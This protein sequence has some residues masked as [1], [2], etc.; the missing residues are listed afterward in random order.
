MGGATLFLQQTHL[1]LFRCSDAYVRFPLLLQNVEDLLHE[2]G[3]D[4]S[5]ERVSSGRASRGLSTSPPRQRADRCADLGL[6]IGLF[7][8]SGILAALYKRDD[9]PE[10]QH[11]EVSMLE[12]SLNMMANYIPSVATLGL[13]FRGSAAAVPPSFRMRRSSA[14]MANM[15]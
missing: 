3:T 8:L 9:H 6:Y 13:G 2:R 11:V 14:R 10:G 12:A 7:L 4:I 15:S 1:G 5:H